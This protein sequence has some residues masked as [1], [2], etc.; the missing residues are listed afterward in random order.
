MLGAQK[1][2]RFEEGNDPFKQVI[3]TADDE[4]Q[5]GVLR[6]AVVRLDPSTA[7]AQLDQVEDLTP[8]RILTDVKLWY[9]LP[10]GSRTEVLLDGDV[11]RAFSVDVARDVG[12]Q[13]FL[14]IDRTCRIVTVHS[15]RVTTPCDKNS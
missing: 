9:E 10:T 13:S 12:I 2:L 8:L 15:P 4:H 11:K 6:A 3:T 5:A 7:Q 1:W 14:L